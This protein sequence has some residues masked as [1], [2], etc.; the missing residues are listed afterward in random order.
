VAEALD[1]IAR[2]ER[3]Q[4]QFQAEL[5]EPFVYLSDEWYYLARRSFPRAS[6][7]GDY[8]Q[9]ENGVGMTRYLLD[10][11]RRTRGQLPA[12]LGAPRRLGLVTSTMAEPVL[13]QLARDL[14]RVDGL[15]V[16]LLP[17]VN[18][19]FGPTTTVAGLLCG[20]DALDAVRARCADFTSD[21]LVLLP[22]VMLDNAGA[23]F[24]DD[25]AV[26]EFSAQLT[27]RVAFA[28]TAAEI[29]AAVASLAGEPVAV[30]A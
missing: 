24:L 4:R 16:R 20:Q 14:R 8:A 28:K 9:I 19:F 15:E 30:M 27:P 1:V 3:W 29:V 6:H 13:R 2:V 18:R 10:T 12:T 26:A 11:W 7:Y 17:V 21:D 23:R 5:G 22:R 25:M